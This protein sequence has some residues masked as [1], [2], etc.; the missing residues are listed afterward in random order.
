MNAAALPLSFTS[1]ADS[2]AAEARS[3]LTTLSRP[4]LAF[5]V[6]PAA[7]LIACTAAPQLLRSVNPASADVLLALIAL[8]L[9]SALLLAGAAPL[10]AGRLDR[11]IGSR[12]LQALLLL[13]AVTA[14]SMLSAHGATLKNPSTEWL[15]YGLPPLALLAGAW[16]LWPVRRASIGGR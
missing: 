7:G 10:L 8:P 16:L 11:W 1:L 14:V 6:L 15:A 5:A 3:T 9:W 13:A 2:L 4:C 12:A